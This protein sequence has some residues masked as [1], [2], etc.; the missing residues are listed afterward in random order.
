MAELSPKE[1]SYAIRTAVL[2]MWGLQSDGA[3]VA[4]G[5][6]IT[7]DIGGRVGMLTI[8]FKDSEIEFLR[9]L[10]HTAAV[11]AEM[12]D[13]IWN[14][15]GYA[16]DQLEKF[17]LDLNGDGSGWEAGCIFSPIPE[18]VLRGGDVAAMSIN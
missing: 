6:R 7:E 2:I 16:E 8:S 12:P 10:C 13:S 17:A 15:P 18:P 1:I 3:L 9:N 14:I 4:A 11:A 5:E